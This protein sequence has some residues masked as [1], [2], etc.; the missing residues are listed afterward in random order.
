MFTQHINS[1]TQLIFSSLIIP[2]PSLIHPTSSISPFY[3]FQLSSSR[4]SRIVQ[5]HSYQHSSN[6]PLPL[7]HSNPH[8]FPYFHYF[9][10]PNPLLHLHF[11]DVTLIFTPH[12]YPSTPPHPYSHLHFPLFYT[13]FHDTRFI[14]TF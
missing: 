3:P 1:H 5:T 10:S 8:I 6:S 4:F 12:T 9:I 11:L 14:V 7:Y 2:Y 13:S